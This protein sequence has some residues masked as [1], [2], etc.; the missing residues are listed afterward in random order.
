M[1]AWA[2]LL[3]LARRSH[4][5]VTLDHAVA[6]G[7]APST[8]W[9]RAASE[10][11]ERLYPGVFALPGSA[12]TPER[13]TSGALLAVGGK[14]AACRQTAAYLWGMTDHAP[15]LVD[16]IIPPS[17]R[18]PR[19]EGVRA[20]RSGTVIPADLTSVRGLAVTSPA[21]TVCDLAAVMG[22]DRELRLLVLTARR[23]GMLDLVE[24]RRRH[25]DLARSPGATRLARILD[26]L[27]AERPERMFEHEVRVF[28][29][30]HGLTPHPTPL[31]I[32]CR[33]GRTRQ[34]A[35]PFIDQRVGIEAE[36]GIPTDQEQIQEQADAN[37]ERD[38]ELA[39]VGWR[40]ARLTRRRFQ[41]D[42]ERWL[43][44]LLRL[45]ATPPPPLP[46][47]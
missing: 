6:C 21:R 29:H 32:P 44:S 10:G 2:E 4:H 5:V 47:R 18:A 43:H 36:Y 1:N 27:D 41:Q 17:R 26:E 28:V 25:V 15:H 19:L 42:R 8:L 7:L 40:I 14:V 34:I 31:W 9:R 39:A 24:L 38:I 3:I 46:A 22:D 37:D 16:L 30:S 33:D 45:L 12:A 23:R 13:Q 35:V 20:L 11:W